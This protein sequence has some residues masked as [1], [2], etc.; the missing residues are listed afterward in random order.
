MVTGTIAIVVCGRISP[1]RVAGYGIGF[2]LRLKDYSLGKTTY[3]MQGR[4]HKRGGGLQSG[5]ADPYRAL[6][7]A[8]LDP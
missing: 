6:H 4:R 1:G 7:G 5:D 8:L 2:V 3:A